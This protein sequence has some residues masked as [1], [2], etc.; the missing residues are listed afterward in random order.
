MHK[1]KFQRENPED[2]IFVKALINNK[3]ELNLAIDTAA[4]HT[5]LDSNML[6]LAGYNL[7]DS[8]GEI[9]IETSNG[10]I[11]VEKYKIEHFECLGKKQINFEVQVYDFLVH[12]ITSNYD[13]VIG[14]N[15]LENSILTIDLINNE[16]SVE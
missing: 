4:T 11:I 7:K 14:L 1:Y 8:I 12:G 5:T 13:G 3:F 16:I 9:N 6:Y 10:I 2:L 15:F